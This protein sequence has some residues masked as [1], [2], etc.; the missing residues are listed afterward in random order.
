MLVLVLVFLW[1]IAS[2]WVIFLDVFFYKVLDFDITK[3]QDTLCV[4]ICVTLLFIFIT[5]IVKYF[6]VIPNLEE[7]LLGVS[8]T[9]K[10]KGAT[11]EKVIDLT[12]NPELQGAIIPT[13]SV[14]STLRA[15]RLARGI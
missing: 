14:I 1:V 3:P 7:K 13:D 12:Q 10:I 9:K 8:S 4:A 6:G 11:Y 5:Y 15:E 2:F